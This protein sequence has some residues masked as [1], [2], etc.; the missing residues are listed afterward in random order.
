MII[1]K[2]VMKKIC[3]ASLTALRYSCTMPTAQIL[4]KYPLANRQLL[5]V[6]TTAHNSHANLFT[7]ALQSRPRIR[8]ISN[9]S[10]ISIIHS[11]HTSLMNRHFF[12]TCQMTLEAIINKTIPPSKIGSMFSA[13]FMP[14]N[15]TP[16]LL[17]MS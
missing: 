3:L 11:E 17:V 4:F 1:S 10:T 13:T 5:S 16:I 8:A 15:L 14:L 6:Q 2:K 12:P 7:L 9:L